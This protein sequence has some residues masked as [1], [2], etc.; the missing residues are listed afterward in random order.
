MKT[1]T[2]SILFISTLLLCGCNNEPSVTPPSENYFTVTYLANGGNGN[3]FSE[4]VKENTVYTIKDFMYTAPSNKEFNSWV[5]DSKSYQPGETVTITQDLDIIA[6]YKEAGTTEKTYTVTFNP[7]R[8]TGYME[9]LVVE[10]GFSIQL[11]TCT[12]TPP[13]GQSFYRWGDEVTTYKEKA[14]V[15]INEDTEFVAY[16]V[17]NGKEIY[18]VTFASNG[19]SGVMDPV[20]VEEGLY[21][22]PSCIFNAPSNKTFDYWS[23]STAATH[24]QPEQQINVVSD[25]TVTAN[26]KN[27]VPNRY[28]LSYD[29]NGGS[30]TMSS[31]TDNENTWIYL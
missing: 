16:Y 14:Y 11:P 12:F 18:T 23:I 19:G 5:I 30:G 3:T 24:Y 6:T 2:L 31:Q 13:L 8:G 20:Q 26:W 15:T 17:D 10:E 7:G 21:T 1:K 28:T 4:S 9:P 29:P 22:L 27:I 25:V